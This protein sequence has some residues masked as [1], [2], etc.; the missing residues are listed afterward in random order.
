MKQRESL[1]ESG[2]PPETASRSRPPRRER[3][4][5]ATKWRSTGHII[6]AIRPG[7]SPR[8]WAASKRCQ[9]IASAHWNS[10]LAGAPFSSSPCCSFAYTRS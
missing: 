4:L 8:C 3:I 1:G 6:S 9:P 7:A 10:A 2:A 5:S